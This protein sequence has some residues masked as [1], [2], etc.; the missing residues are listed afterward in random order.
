MAFSIAATVLS[1]NPEALA[2]GFAESGPNLG[3]QIQASGEGYIAACI[4]VIV[5]AG[6]ARFGLKASRLNGLEDPFVAISIPA[7]GQLYEG[8]AAP[9]LRPFPKRCQFSVDWS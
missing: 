1:I 8:G 4:P 7:S 2:G 9:D 5:A 3:R 6:P